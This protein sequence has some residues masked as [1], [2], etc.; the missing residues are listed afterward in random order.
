M[1]NPIQ[2][3][4]SSNLV[5]QKLQDA[6]NNLAVEL[7]KK[8]NGT[9]AVA[10]N[11]TL[12]L[13]SNFFVDLESSEFSPEL[14]SRNDTPRSEIYNKNLLGIYNDLRRFYDD[15]KNLNE[16]QVSSFNFAQILTDELV[17][18][19]NSLASMVLDL[20]IL[21]NFTRGDVLIAGDDFKNSDFIDSSVGLA[22]S[23]ADLVFGGNGLSLARV[24]TKTVTNENTKI[25]VIPLSPISNNNQ[26]NTAPTT[27]NLE[28]F[29]EGNYYNYLGLARPEGGKDFNFKYLLAQTGVSS[30]PA[31]QQSIVVDGQDPGAFLEI[32]AT[33]SDKA[34]VRKRMLDG[35]P[36]TFW[37]CE[38][39]YKV[40]DPLLKIGLPT[41][42]SSDQTSQ[43]V[44]IDLEKAE[45]L[46]KEYDLPGRDLII[47]IILTFPQPEN[48]NIANFNP[49]LFGASSF[50][51]VLDVATASTDTGDF[52]TIDGWNTFRFARVITPEANEFLTS[53]QA[54]L[55]LAPRDGVYSG[56][57][58]FPFPTRT[59]RKLKFR[60]K[61]ASPVASPYER[62]YVLL[63]ND[64]QTTTTVRTTTKKGLFR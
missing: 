56:Q 4:I 29:Y 10:I 61:M 16:V 35:N 8:D 58:I 12:Q 39:L 11:Q 22:S 59:T 62:I 2:I 42:T 46:A 3:P 43:V 38:Y 37:E 7:T 27:A 15:L 40:D 54:G 25:E 50:P 5:T 21:N 49:I 13:I 44:T 31:N 30:N 32:G 20:N 52:E 6:I 57:G 1:T 14:F 45:Q 18:R 55:L 41:D 64:I 51:E 17:A 34:N 26:V 60:I 24:S 33:E 48:I 23:P 9:V 28:R 36:V 19:A 47:D 63:K 53:S